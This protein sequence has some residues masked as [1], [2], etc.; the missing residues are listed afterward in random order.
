MTSQ[1]NP[2]D[3]VP[4]R[5]H[6][7]EWTAPER[8]ALASLLQGGPRTL[9][10]EYRVL[11][12]GCGDGANLL[13]LAN[14]RKHA[15]FIGV[16]GAGSQIEKA[17]AHKAALELSNV[18]FI[19]ADFIT[20]NQQLTGQFDYI[21]AHGI[22]SWVEQDTRDALLKLFA[23]RLR[24][25]GLL[26]LNY[27]TK[28]GWNIRG[29]V[30]DYLLTSTAEAKNLL[31]RAHLA[32]EVSAKMV[33]SLASCEHPYSQLMANEFQF[34]CESHVSYITHEFLAKDNHAYWRSEFLSLAKNHGLEYVGDADFNY[35]SGRVPG[36]LAAQLSDEQL[37]GDTPSDTID[38]VCYRQ[39]HSPI[40]AQAPLTS[41]QP[42]VEEFAKLYIASCLIESTP[43][44]NGDLMFQHPSG[45]EVEA[46]EKPIQ[47]AL[48]RLQSLWPQGLRVN[49]VFS[50]VGEVMDDLKLLQH[51]GLI[52][53][54]CIEP[55]DLGERSARLSRLEAESGGYVTT[56][57]HTIETAPAAI[58]DAPMVSCPSS[59]ASGVQI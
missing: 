37:L 53:L 31:H 49:E 29:M 17:G 12:L 46:R 1:T 2:Y 55:G 18:E 19:H 27:N 44:D 35:A 16:D 3:E 9:L 14:Y 51:S 32:Q 10:N 26:Y 52:E 45:Y 7:I 36:D 11:E 42:S 4:Y 24:R 8:L 22:F 6:P 59:L 28:P 41:S 33:L 34:V 50:N 23:Q 40:L 54:R 39:L 13:P 30:R 43:N 47:V 15:T 5:S 58:V 21:I 38:L 20:A 57:Y 48:K 25:D 56:P